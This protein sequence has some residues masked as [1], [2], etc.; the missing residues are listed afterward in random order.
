MT[1]YVFNISFTFL[2]DCICILLSVQTQVNHSILKLESSLIHRPNEFL[3]WSVNQASFRG[4]H[5]NF[6]SKKV[7]Y[8]SVD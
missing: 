6:A 4:V 8:N 2:F 3:V 1:P 5:F 7:A